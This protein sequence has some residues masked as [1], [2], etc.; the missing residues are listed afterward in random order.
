MITGQ[1]KALV[2]S[3]AILGGI[4]FGQSS[5]WSPTFDVVDDIPR[6]YF[7]EQRTIYGY[8]ERVIDGDTMRVTHCPRFSSCPPSA[9][10]SSPSTGR[11]RIW[12][13]TLKL[14]IYGVDSPEL[15]KKST[16]PPSQPYADEA[17]DFASQLVLGKKVRLKLLRKDQYNRAIVKVE[18]P[19]GIVP[20][21]G[22]RK[23]LSVELVRRGYA[24]VYR[25]GGA[26]YDSKKELLEKLEA[27]ARRRRLGLWSVDEKERVSPAEFKRQQKEARSRSKPKLVPATETSR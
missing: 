18:T 4:G 7:S 27:Q 8:V 23:D 21:V 15:Q 5:F 17:R 26:A 22:R 25:G 12:D 6:N 24:T 11:K 1:A 13:K 14:R 3:A 16:D 10:S 2:L 19:R 20:I 9:S